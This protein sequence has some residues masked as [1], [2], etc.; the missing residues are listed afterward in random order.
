MT[1]AASLA[2]GED[3]LG[4]DDFEFV[5]GRAASEFDRVD[6]DEQLLRS[7]AAQ[8]GGVYHTLATAGRIPDEI[9]QRRAL[10]AR[11]S[12]ISLWNAPGFFLVFLACVTTEWFL[13]KR[14][15][16]P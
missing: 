9:R 8:T 5:V 1:A 16:L 14:R 6:V 3:L 11:R 7:L 15:G 2:D 12:E 13:R 4:T 10:V